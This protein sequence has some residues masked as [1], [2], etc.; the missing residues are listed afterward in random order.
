MIHSK[1]LSTKLKSRVHMNVSPRITMIRIRLKMTKAIKKFSLR[2][3]S[4]TP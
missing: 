2:K 3:L 4:G 1:S